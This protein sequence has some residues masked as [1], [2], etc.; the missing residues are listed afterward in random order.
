MLHFFEKS[1]LRWISS[2]IEN[3]VIEKERVSSVTFCRPFIYRHNVGEGKN[4]KFGLRSK[5]FFLK[6]CRIL[7]ICEYYDLFGV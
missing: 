1:G 5:T 7:S 4:R 2:D 6:R 3:L